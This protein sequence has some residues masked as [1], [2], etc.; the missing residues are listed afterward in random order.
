MGAS[1]SQSSEQAKASTHQPQD[2]KLQEFERRLSQLTRR[3]LGLGR[4]GG[5]FVDL[6]GC[7]IWICFRK[8]KNCIE[9]VAR[10]W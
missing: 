5:G 4:F 6:L 3:P 7:I 2:F 9:G 10:K 1:R 8:L